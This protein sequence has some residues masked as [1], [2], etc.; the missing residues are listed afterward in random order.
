MGKYDQLK[1]LKKTKARVNHAC[2]KCGREIESNSF[3]Y[4][5]TVGDKFLH[6]L[7]AKKFCAEC[8]EKFGDRLM[9]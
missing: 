5:E 4:K 7:R 8:Y 6:S 9:N 1:Y 3:Y 2:D